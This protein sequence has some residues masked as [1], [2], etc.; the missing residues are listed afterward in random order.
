MKTVL[1][2][3]ASIALAQQAAHM[4]MTR[5]DLVLATH[6]Q[7]YG[8]SVSWVELPEGRILM[9]GG[10]AFR[11]STDKGITWSPEFQPKNEKGASVS[12]EALV[13][14]S[15]GAIGMIE[16][17]PKPGSR[18]DQRFVFRRSNDGGRTWVD[19]VAVEP[20]DSKTYIWQDM[21]IRTA[22][23]RLILPVYLSIG[24]G[25]D[26]LP[27]TPHVGGYIAGSGPW[28][29]T[30]AHFFDP[31]FLASF[32][33]LSDDEGR[34]WRRNRD[35]EL[36][37]N[38]TGG[39]SMELTAEPSVAEVMPGKLLMMMRT[40]LG[41]LFQAWSQDNG[42]TWS[43]PEPTQLAGT[44][45]PAMVRPLKG[46]A[47]GHV[48]CVF[49]QHSEQ[50]IRQGFI[51]TRLSSA[52]SRNGGRFWENFQN[53]E[54]IHPEPRVE[55]GPVRV[56]RPGGAYPLA[57]GTAGENDPRATVPLP[58]GYGRWSYPSVLVL[59]DR[60][61]ISH[62]YSWH[63]ETGARRNAGGSRLKVLPLTWF[64]GGRE[65]YQNPDVRKLSSPPQP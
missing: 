45:A 49:N 53:V 51:R 6:E 7:K 43:R 65:P 5:P 42:E 10:R 57:W 20:R 19:P 24:Q 40:R 32:V 28:V 13:N 59:D 8:H 36:L 52:I 17:V 16:V 14:L 22:S 64:Y 47:A 48:L 62:T 54:S 27:G 61:L 50:E 26:H 30:D 18:D 56:V 63:D 46:K 12:P 2:L 44:Q 23:G 31:N 1:V 9:S 60:V 4:P 33:Y 34:T 29:S 15:G 41:R 58:V 25:G 39:G 55:A 11:I 37:I 3:T 38:V 21:L 35:G